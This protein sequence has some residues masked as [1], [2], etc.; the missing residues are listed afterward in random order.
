M[1]RSASL[2]MYNLPP[3]RPVN[4]AF[5][6]ALAALLRDRGIHDLPATLAFERPAVPDA[7]G[8]E[9]L[10]TQTCGYPLG[11]IYRGQHALLG[12][13]DYRE[14]DGPA[15][16]APGTHR[17]LFVVRADDPAQRIEDLRGR[18]FACNSRHSNTGMNLPRRT[19]APLAGGQPFFARVAITGTHP[20]SMALVQSGGADAASIDSLTYA[21]HADHQ[22]EAVAGL[23]I[24]AATVPSPAIPF[25]TS[26]ATDSATQ[27][28]LRDALAAFGQA[29]AHAALRQAL[30][31]RA[32]LPPDAADYAVLA[33]YEA[34]A[35]ALGYPDLA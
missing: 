26:A 13:P 32:I 10:F 1:T 15:T 34:E 30:R 19:L 33:R 11:T 12:V 27:A 21:F 2:P 20:A 16:S 24:L 17:G 23:R 22:P 18:V 4:A 5:W 35:S 6:D 28:A 7:I 9:V 8:P 31:L 3:M 29:P 25:V 14:A